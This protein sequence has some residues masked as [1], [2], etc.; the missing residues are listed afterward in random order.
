VDE[1]LA[2]HL[3]LDANTSYRGLLRML[4]RLLLGLSWGSPPS[5]VSVFLAAWPTR[6]ERKSW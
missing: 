3:S 4:H 6:R 5:H 2:F 1:V